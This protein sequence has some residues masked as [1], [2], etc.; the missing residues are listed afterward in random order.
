MLI[1]LV[2]VFSVIGLIFVVFSAWGAWEISR[3]EDMDVELE[4]EE[5]GR[6]MWHG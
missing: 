1:E 3:W 6:E 2:V 4:V 5:L